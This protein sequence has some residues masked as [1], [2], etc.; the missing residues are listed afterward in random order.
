MNV[1]KLVRF[2]IPSAT[3]LITS[4]TALTGV[5]PAGQINAQ[6]NDAYLAR[7]YDDALEKY[8]RALAAAE[9]SKDKQYEA[10]AAFGLARTYA[11]LCQVNNSEKWFKQSI[12]IREALPD[13]RDAYMTQN[14]LEYGRFLAGQ[15][16]NEDAVKLYDRAMPIL[17]S[18]EMEK[19]DPLGYAL[20]FDEYA[21]LLA[22][23]NRTNDASVAAEKAESLRST[24]KGKAVQFKPKPYPNCK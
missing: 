6:G 1:Y 17:E 3:L 7:R 10:I 22:S 11:Q 4:C 18:L 14:F 13:R 21:T 24:N 8:Q 12:S 9:Q 2:I 5:P 19:R 15:G 23:T 16:Q 20:V